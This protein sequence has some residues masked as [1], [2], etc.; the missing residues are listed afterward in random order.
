M[1]RAMNWLVG[2][3]LPYDLFIWFGASST[4]KFL[5]LYKIHLDRDVPILVLEPSVNKQATSVV[6]ILSPEGLDLF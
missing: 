1:S 3:N 4:Q 5:N 6:L 2:L